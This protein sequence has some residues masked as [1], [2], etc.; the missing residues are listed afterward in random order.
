MSRKDDKKRGSQSDLPALL[1]AEPDTLAVVQ[2][3]PPEQQHLL[4]Q[5][6]RVTPKRGR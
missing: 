3:I 2:T 1:A 6:L 5:A 4:A